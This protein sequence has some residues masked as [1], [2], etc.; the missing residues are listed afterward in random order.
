MTIMRL[1]CK[2]TK[3][4]VSSHNIASDIAAWDKPLSSESQGISSTWN[5][6]LSGTAQVQLTGAPWGAAH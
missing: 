3:K 5:K 4:T 6:S 1:T 2:T